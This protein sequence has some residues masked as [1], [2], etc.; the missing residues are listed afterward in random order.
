MGFGHGPRTGKK[1]RT[2]KLDLKALKNIFAKKQDYKSGQ[3]EVK[4]EPKVMSFDN[5]IKNDINTVKK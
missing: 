4:K 3:G 5:F 2:K 1:S